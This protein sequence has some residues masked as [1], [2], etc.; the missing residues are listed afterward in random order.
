MNQIGTLTETVNTL[1][2]AK[3]GGFSTVVSARSG[4]TEDATLADLAVGLNGG[5]IKI[6][7]V[8]GS[9][10]LSKYNQLLR[11]NE[12]IGNNYSGSFVFQSFGLY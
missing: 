6:G 9:S 1:R 4:E 7:S 3:N 10:R 12:V 11:I 8:A 5:Q 2:M